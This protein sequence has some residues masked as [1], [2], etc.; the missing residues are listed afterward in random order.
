MR[1]VQLA[2]SPT[3]IK[4]GQVDKFSLSWLLL[5]FGECFIT[6]ILPI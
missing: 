4:E 5:Y 1:S 2:I 3:V 6:I